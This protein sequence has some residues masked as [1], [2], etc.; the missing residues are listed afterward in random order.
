MQD[1]NHEERCRRPV[2]HEIRKDGPEEHV[3]I[4]QVAPPMPQAGRF[5][6]FGELIP[7]LSENP[8][9]SID[10]AG[11]NPAPRCSAD[12]RPLGSKA[13]TGSS[14]RLAH[15]IRVRGHLTEE[16]LSVNPP[17]RVQIF[18]ACRD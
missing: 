14:A 3:S 1:A 4:R 16:V 11:R 6:S 10:V 7:Q 18:E 2:H 9:G 15:C 17:I 5:R 8:I 13:Y 12:R